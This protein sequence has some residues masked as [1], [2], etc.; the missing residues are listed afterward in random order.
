M[1]TEYLKDYAADL[2]RILATTRTLLASWALAAVLGAA[3][4]LA[5]ALVHGTRSA[6]AQVQ[7]AV[8]KVVARDSRSGHVRRDENVRQF[9]HDGKA[10]TSPTLAPPG[11]GGT[12]HRR[13][14][15]AGLT[16]QRVKL[17]V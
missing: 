9:A 13:G 14:A 1:F 8:E 3:L 7:H 5:P 4:L 6:Q 15:A 2:G 17:T 11:G 10:E 16:I 12:R